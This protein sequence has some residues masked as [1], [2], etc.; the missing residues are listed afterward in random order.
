MAAGSSLNVLI[1]GETG[2]GKGLLARAIHGESEERQGQI[3]ESVNCAAIPGDLIEAT[4]FGH[5]KGAFTGAHASNVG[6]LE[7]ADRGTVFLDE[8]GEMTLEA[9]KKL[10]TFLDDG[11]FRPVGG[12]QRRTDVRIIG[13]S[14]QALDRAIV[15]RRF[16]EPLYYRLAQF[17]ITL[18]PLRERR[19][20]IPELA[21]NLL[22]R[23][24][25]AKRRQVAHIAQEALDLLARQRFPGNIRELRNVIDRAAVYCDGSEIKLDDCLA[26]LD[27]KE[28]PAPDRGSN[29]LDLQM[30]LMDFERLRLQEALQLA[31]GNAEEASRLLGISKRW[32]YKLKGKHRLR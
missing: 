30:G 6:V 10:L 9:Q 4:L 24:R 17:R 14:S 29:D 22:S 11:I 20:D 27:E 13:A 32:L 16:L 25:E 15:E 1:E 31:E 21:R 12:R 23:S 28:G 19:R 2:T 8:I 7:I 26:A 5:V 3:F 18:P